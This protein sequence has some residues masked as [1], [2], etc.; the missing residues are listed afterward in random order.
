MKMYS[1]LFVAFLFY[2]ASALEHTIVTPRA[3]RIGVWE[4]VILNLHD[5]EAATVSAYL[6]DLP[7]RQNVFS[8]SDDL[9]FNSAKDQPIV[10]PMRVRSEDILDFR[11]QQKVALIIEV[12]GSKQDFTEE[13]EVL[14]TKESGYL[15]ITTDQPAYKPNAQVIARVFP[16]NQL[17]RQEDKIIVTMTI[18]TPDGV[19]L[20][21]TNKLLPADDFIEIFYKLSET[22]EIGTWFIEANYTTNGYET[23]TQ[24][25]FSV[26]RYVLPTYQVSIIPDQNFALLSDD[27]IRGTIRATYS[28]GEPVDGSYFFSMKLRR[29]PSSAPVEIYT[30]PD[31]D[32][33]TATI[34]NGRKT[35]S[36]S[37]DYV[38]NALLE[39]EDLPTLVANKAAV[40]IEVT[41]RGEAEGVLESAVSDDLPFLTSPYVIDTQRASKYY[42]PGLAYILQ[43]D[44]MDALK[45]KPAPNVDL[46]I[47]VGAEEFET[48]SDVRGNINYQ[49]DFAGSEPQDLFITTRDPA[50]NDA[51][52]T[53]VSLAIRPYSSP[54]TSYLQIETTRSV[55][56]VGEPAFFITFKFNKNVKEIRYYVVARGSIVHWNINTPRENNVES[57]EQLAI[58]QKMVPSAR[59][60]AYYLQGTEIVSNSAWFDVVDQCKEELVVQVPDTVTPGERFDMQISGSPNARVS[61]SGVDRAAYFLYDE[62]RLTR[63]RMFEKMEE[64]DQGCVRHGGANGQNVFKEAGLSLTTSTIRTPPV[65]SLSCE[66]EGQ[67]RKK[68]QILA[69]L[70]DDESL[71]CG[72][73]GRLPPALPDET[74]TDRAV[75]CEINYPDNP[76]CCEQFLEECIIATKAR[77]LA[78][79]R[80]IAGRSG[81]NRD[82]AQRS[83]ANVRKDF[84][85]SLIFTTITLD[86]DG[87]H[88]LLR[89]SRD[90]ITIFDIDAVSM[91][92]EQD[93]FCIAEPTE[94]RVFKDVFIQL[95]TPYSLKKREQ[96]TI[97]YSIFNY[98]KNNAYEVLV[99]VKIEKQDDLD[100]LCSHFPA[101]NFE[102]VIQH[103]VE[104]E[105]TASGSFTV[106]PLRIPDQE[107]ASIEMQIRNARTNQILD[108]ILK[109][110]LIEDAGQIQ[111]TYGSYAIDLKHDLRQEF[112]IHFDFPDNFVPGTRK[113]WIYAY[114]NFL[115]P[116]IEIDEVTQEPRNIESIFRMPTGCGEQSLLKAGPNIYAHMY[117]EQAGKLVEGTPA[118]EASLA[119]MRQ[120]YGIQMGYRSNKVGKRAFAV[121]AHHDPSTW[122]N[123]FA[124]KVYSKAKDY[125]TDIDI[126]PVCSSLEWLLGEQENDGSFRELKRVY[127]REMHGAVGGKLTLTAYVL[128]TLLETRSRCLNDLNSRIED[129]IERAINYLETNENHVT[130]QQRPYALAILS[131]ALALNNPYSPFARRMNDRLLSLRRVTD[132]QQVYWKGRPASEIAGTHLH[133]YWYKT[134]P[135][136]IDVEATAYALLAQVE[137]AKA[138]NPVLQ[139]SIDLTRKIV[140]WLIGQRNEGGAFISTQDT[141]IGLQ[142]LATYEIWIDGVDANDEPVDISLRLNSAVDTTWHNPGEEIRLDISN[143]RFKIEKRVPEDVKNT[144]GLS[145]TA[146]G[147]GEGIVSYRCV[148]RTVVDEE[149]CHFQINHNV[150]ITNWDEV[151]RNRVPMIIKI[152][153]TVEKRVGD[154][155]Q[156]SIIEVGLLSGFSAVEQTIQR[157]ATEQ[158][159]DGMVDRYEITD[160]NVV[161]YL[162][163]IT[164]EGVTVAFDM[165]QNI[166]VARPEPA[167][168]KVYDYYEPS[169][170]CG[171]FYTLPENLPNLRTANC[172]QGNDDA[173]CKC[174]EGGCVTCRSRAQQLEGATCLDGAE[175][176]CAIC[177]GNVC[178]NAFTAACKSNFLY[179]INVTSVPEIGDIF[180]SFKGTIKDILKRG[181]DPNVAKN[182]EATFY[183][184][185]DCFRN[186][187]DES[188]E[189]AARNNDNADGS[190]FGQGNLLIVMGNAPDS[191]ERNGVRMHNYRLDENAVIER[192]IPDERCE[193]AKK[194]K[195]RLH[196]DDPNH[197]K[198]ERQEERCERFTKLAKACD[199]FDLLQRRL[200]EGC[201]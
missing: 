149:S 22:P 168:I 180:Y 2:K 13:V 88:A 78:L 15:F 140:L 57:S 112:D 192:W 31:E 154:P 163:E 200:E 35:Y 133:A 83:V 191:N 137:I 173:L 79:I 73:D 29:T 169:I 87:N 74:C 93:G 18:K 115:G 164:A 134:R 5:Y 37:M 59:I 155:A 47:R 72:R 148:Y 174:A 66:N 136:A 39:G 68:R 111:D 102:Y 135:Q 49:L 157:L 60:V 16:L 196:C 97:K 170:H 108:T 80:G 190:Y 1:V 20:H 198:T 9:E 56:S 176:D 126:R 179:I 128:I 38:R 152:T 138:N 183:T 124:D 129:S 189:E 45:M 40:F 177:N 123:A 63:E 120:G 98:D 161:L 52:Q 165:I 50:L 64:Y 7:R 116:S 127:H 30:K 51:D 114:V 42:T 158:V 84:Q 91:A 144:G 188:L 54:S 75:R 53:D 65:D 150:I 11:Q 178:F 106:L 21:R 85:E 130:F 3:F 117:L 76:T 28:Y 58:T 36:V 113:C 41:V 172:E 131:Y 119:K 27:A 162:P 61:I 82:A 17:M 86:Q 167:N 201:D 146:T 156:M 121:Y 70:E 103:S 151:E 160:Q 145:V 48:T 81:A 43:V 199:N 187:R 142:A 122:L 34:S 46:L 197:P 175:E 181:D 69:A 125:A 104:S 23:S 182:S 159:A 99:Y 14:V 24:T 26:K 153:I 94:L 105:G 6:Q 19:G 10:L 194:N 4:N 185:S 33:G 101:G 71:F 12:S 67:S 100:T 25:T 141:V 44:T 89:K 95:Y 90:S 132:N 195:R 184:R 171:Q 143:E 62:S 186:C 110:V 193:R 118:Y 77:H 96:A 139:T 107:T 32:R 109:E 8:E 92:D 147:N 55:A 166:P